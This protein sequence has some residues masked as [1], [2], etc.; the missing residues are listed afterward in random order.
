MDRM[1][2]LT[3]ALTPRVP[4]ELRIRPNRSWF[5]IDWRGLWEYRDLLALLVRRDFVTVYK[6]TILGPLWFFIQ[7]LFATIIFTFVFGK[8]AGIST[9]GLPGPLF[10]IAGITIWNY[11]SECVLKA[12]SAF[13]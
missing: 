13:K 10:Y 8:V 3:A 2:N 9:D 4:Y 5:R 6:Q 11:F 7:P 12:S 1:E